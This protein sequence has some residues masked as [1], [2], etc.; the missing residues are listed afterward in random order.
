M[1]KRILSAVLFLVCL[2]LFTGCSCS[3][4]WVEA[5]CLNPKTCSECQ[6]TE[7]EA[8]GHDWSDATCEAAKTCNRCAETKGDPLGHAWSDA[9]C[10]TA[11][12]CTR[13]SQVEGDALGHTPGDWDEK[14]DAIACTFSRERYCSVC[15]TLTDTEAGS[16]DTLRSNGLF[17]FTPEEF[18][19]RFAQ[20][21]E[22]N[23]VDFSYEYVTDSNWLQV[24]VYSGSKLALIQ[25]FRNDT[26]AVAARAKDS[27]EVW[28]VSYLA[29]GGGDMDVRRCF[30]MA[31]DPTLD[32]DSAHAVS[33]QLSMEYL[34]AAT[35]G[36]TYGYYVY[37]QLLYEEL[38]VDEGA[39]GLDYS[40]SMVNI[41][42]SDFR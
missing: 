23:A 13:C 22:Q 21:A 29:Y 17:L 41:Y 26:T 36:K 15:G 4:S 9:T 24:Y 10:E 40:L 42:A 6:E 33:L 19:E 34:N 11:K 2:L 8:L 31:C 7:G 20:I 38:F 25:F 16:L 12:T 35:A 27:K 28:C 18:M 30:L 37:N 5:D 32:K 1:K 3:H 39:S 14:T